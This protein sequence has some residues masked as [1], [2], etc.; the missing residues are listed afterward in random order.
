MTAMNERTPTGQTP[1]GDT[2]RI[3][4]RIKFL[5]PTRNGAVTVW[6]MV[7]GAWVDGQPTVR[8]Q[9]CANFIVHWHEIS[10]VDPAVS[11]VE[12]GD[13]GSVPGAL[14]DSWGLVFHENGL[15]P[16]KACEVAS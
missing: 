6:R 14:K 11:C 5:S 9:G 7:N 10:E 13:T 2:V 3:G 1:N 4:D 15:V 12:C 16:C 8:F